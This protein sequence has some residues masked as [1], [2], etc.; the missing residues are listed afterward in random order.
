MGNGA[1]KKIKGLCGW[2]EGGME[3]REKEIVKQTN[4]ASQFTEKLSI[5]MSPKGLF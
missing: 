1:E 3:K 4:K 2:V 5:E